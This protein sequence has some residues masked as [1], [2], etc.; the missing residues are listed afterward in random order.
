MFPAARAFLPLG[1]Y[2][3]VFDK[4]CKA[5]GIMDLVPHA[6]RH[7]TASL[8]IISAGANIKVLQRLLRHATAAM[9]LDAA[10]TCS[11]MT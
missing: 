6:L 9:T 10:A 3:W 8:A 5:G 4:A 1:D 7:T 11:V 2:R